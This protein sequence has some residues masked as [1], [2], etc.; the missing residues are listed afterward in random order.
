MPRRPMPIRR[1]PP[2]VP[3]H[4]RARLRSGYWWR[5][6]GNPIAVRL[7]VAWDTHPWRTVP[8]VVSTVGDVVISYSGLK[9]GLAYT[10]DFT[11]Q[12]RGAGD[13]AEVH[14][15]AGALNMADLRKPHKLP[16]ADIVFVGT[17]A[18]RA[19]RM[20]AQASMVMPMR[21]HFVIDYDADFDAVFSRAS[22]G[23]RRDFRQNMRKHQ[24]DL[25]IEKDPTWFNHFYR[26]M[27]LPTMHG[28][29]GLRSRTEEVESAYECLFRT[30]ILF[31]LNMDG[32]RIG[33]HLCH[34]N[35]RTGVLTSR[36]LGVRDGADELY[37]L[38]AL[39]IMYFLM[40]EW[41][42]KN[43]VSTFDLQGTEAFL[44]K[45]TFQMKRRYGSRVVLPPNHFGGKRLWV[46]VRHDRPA[47]RDF[48]VANPF[49]TADAD[50]RL[51]A[52]YFFDAQRRV[53]DLQARSP[54]IELARYIDL[55]E[56]LGSSVRT[57]DPVYVT[58][59]R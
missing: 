22:K 14:R 6:S 46:Q 8:A 49:V 3:L 5:N 18:A 15:T 26:D 38:S 24:W 55:D 29:Y 30:G 23:A 53:S 57:A 44:S 56:F 16:D 50:G 31:Y 37:S 34:W 4:R 1:H 35:R 51:Q 10:L 42:S 11:E 28:R 36:L 54:G 12:Q 39:K 25:G 9:E 45:G 13:Q 19:Y 40:I 20:P 59:T 27:Y 17:S 2:R 47:V 7:H 58:L 43:G 21:V 33:G 52:V 48:L 32:N 41:A